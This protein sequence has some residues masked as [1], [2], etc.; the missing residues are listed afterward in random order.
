LQGQ[1]KAKIYPYVPFA[2]MLHRSFDK[3]DVKFKIYL[4]VSYYDRKKNWGLQWEERHHN[5]DLVL[6]GTKTFTQECEPFQIS[7]L[8][9]AEDHFERGAIGLTSPGKITG[10]IIKKIEVIAMRSPYFSLDIA[11]GLNIE[12]GTGFQSF[13][14]GI[15]AV[16]NA[17]YRITAEA[18]ADRF[19]EFARGAA[20]AVDETIEYG[21]NCQILVRIKFP[22]NLDIN[23]H[24]LT[25]RFVP[26]YGF[27]NQN[28]SET[29]DGLNIPA[30]MLD[31][32]QLGFPGGI[33][34][35][36]SSVDLSGENNAEELYADILN[37]I[38]EYQTYD[39]FKQE[40]EASARTAY[41]NG[42]TGNYDVT[43]GYDSYLAGE[44][45][46]FIEVKKP[47]H[48]EFTKQGWQW[49]A[50][51]NYELTGD[52]SPIMVSWPYD[53]VEVNSLEATY[54][55]NRL[56]TLN[57]NPQSYDI[58][59]TAYEIDVAELESRSVQY[60]SNNPGVINI[61]GWF[62]RSGEG[63]SGF[64]SY[65]KS[66]NQYFNKLT[67][68]PGTL[69]PVPDYVVSPA[70][71]V[72]EQ[73][74]VEMALSLDT[75][76][77]NSQI[78]LSWQK[79]GQAWT[80]DNDAVLHD[81]AGGAI[82]DGPET[83]NLD[84]FM[85]DGKSLPIYYYSAYKDKY[86]KYHNDDSADHNQYTFWRD[87]AQSGSLIEN[88]NLV[89]DRWQVDLKDGAGEENQDLL[90]QDQDIHDSY[91][92][93]KLKYDSKEKSLVRV[94]GRATPNST[95]EL[96]YFDGSKWVKFDEGTTDGN[97]IIS[98][99]IDVGRLCGKYT[100]LLKT[101]SAVASQDVYFGDLVYYGNESLNNRRVASAYKRA[102]L[103][104]EPASFDQDQFAS[105][106]PV[107][108]D[109]IY[110]RN[111]PILKTHGPIVELKP[112][113]YQFKTPS[114]DGIEGRPLL[115]F[116]YTAD[117]LN[118]GYGILV[119][120]NDPEW[121]TKTQDLW[122]HQVTADGDLE[123]VQDKT[124]Q[125]YADSNGNQYF[126]FE[127]AVDHFSTYALLNGKFQLSAPIVFS[128]RYITNKETVTIYGTAESMSIITVYVK[129]EQKVP[130]VENSEPYAD[131]QT[132]DDK[133]NFR[134]EGVK[135]LKEDGQNYIYVT[136]HDKK[137]VN[138]RTMSDLSVEKDTVPPKVEAE[139]TLYAF[140]PNDDGK[141]DTVDY[142][143]KTDEE[144]KLY[145]K[146]S[147]QG[148][149]NAG[150]LFDEAIEAGTN[151]QYKINWTNNAFRIFE[152]GT[153][154]NWEQIEER[155]LQTAYSDGQYV[156]AIYAIDRA[157]N[158]SDN[159]IRTTV[160]DNT[161]PKIVSLTDSPDPF[162]PNDDGVKDTATITY[163]LSE[164]SFVRTQI[165]RDDDKLF[166]K[167]EGP[168]ANF[169][170]PSLKESVVSR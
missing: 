79:S 63:L 56:N 22:D 9:R 27:V 115:R 49:T 16:E 145:I 77:Q 167:H 106:T 138:I 93:A 131:R 74:P 35:N 76:D 94:T 10:A 48:G 62:R 100:V 148:K 143:V 38:T 112:S 122:I 130:D 150:A 142:L 157:G 159:V 18:Q 30:K 20:I 135:L 155:Q 101:S 31:V 46:D 2:G 153:T 21:P 102:E 68:T 4:N 104:F 109:T 139:P 85:A 6:E 82:L 152:P 54:H 119:A 42:Y 156:T 103:V 19:A 89:I 52:D 133:G 43:S 160:V 146:I 53:S 95:Y 70:Y 34:F 110:I 124:Q 91:F 147:G 57:N 32:T 161:P 45:F 87:S 96:L 71:S 162:T 25:N 80:T 86:L 164:P 69:L 67:S 51:A 144:G 169:L 33:F 50:Q 88:P 26:W 151:K 116:L 105:V 59:N 154:A 121:K 165:L 166:R 84:G 128:D 78:I 5:F 113:P 11:E 14:K 111:K 107:T 114:E 47:D 149:A 65:N 125:L 158:I 23:N 44:H 83:F 40:L 24:R 97:G 73:S 170:Y 75:T 55:I 134:F 137:N 129:G 29:T 41:F 28:H 12:Q 3:V 72:L 123:L 13:G 92:Q 126:A 117:D 17:T 118:E 141:F 132:A 58:S 8:V 136:S 120:P 36:D 99:F 64:L 163:K 61:D 140:S 108:M 98:A 127:G 37:K 1:Q 81:Y 7:E 168:T 15:F 39:V 66:E 90:V 60:L